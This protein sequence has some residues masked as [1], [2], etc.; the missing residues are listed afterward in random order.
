MEAQKPAAKYALSS[1]F[2]SR[3]PL[4]QTSTSADDRKRKITDKN[5][6]N[7]LLQSPDFAQD[8]AMY[9]DLLQMERKLDWTMTRKRVE[10][11]DALQRIIP[12]SAAPDSVAWKCV[13]LAFPRDTPVDRTLT[14]MLGRGLRRT[15]DADA[16]DI[17][18]PH[19]L[20]TALA[21]RGRRGRCCQAE[22]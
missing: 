17:P 6:P 2:S 12:V 9:R 13:G 18:E 10:V 14:R 20:G 11:H 1:F 21:A 4:S 7:A 8:S 16:P 3:P 15:G 22:S 19:R 5:L